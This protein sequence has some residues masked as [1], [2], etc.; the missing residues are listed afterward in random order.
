MK[1]KKTKDG[2][3]IAEG[4]EVKTFDSAYEAWL[5]IFILKGIRP[6]ASKPRNAL[7]PVK[8]LVPR[9]SKVVKYVLE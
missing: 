9:G 8:E 4:T 5:Y 2:W 7:Y 3:T 6:S 1:L